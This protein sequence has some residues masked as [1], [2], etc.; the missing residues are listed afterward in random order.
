MEKCLDDV[1]KEKACFNLKQLEISGKDLIRIGMPEGKE[2]GDMLNKLLEKV[3]SGEVENS[4]EKLMEV[5]S[6][7]NFLP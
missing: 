3:I 2:I 6:N 7:E 1:L 4:R 5:M